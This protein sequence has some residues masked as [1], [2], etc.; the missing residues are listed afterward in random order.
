MI[1]LRTL[2]GGLF[3]LLLLDYIGDKLQPTRASYWVPYYVDFPVYDYGEC[4]SLPYNGVRRYTVI[5]EQ[6]PKP[7]DLWCG[8]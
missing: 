2:C 4:F 8:T 6:K 1:I 7:W 5:D 3:A